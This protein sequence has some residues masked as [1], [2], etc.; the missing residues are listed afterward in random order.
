LT[1]VRTGANI[2]CMNIQSLNNSPE[3]TTRNPAEYVVLG[4]LSRGPIHGYDLYRSLT[5]D[6]GAVWS[7]GLSQVYA[8]L[9]RLEAAGLVRHQRSTRGRGPGRK[10]FQLTEAGR[11]AFQHWVETPVVHVRDIRLEFLAKLHFARLAGRGA[12]TRL[13]RAQRRVCRDKAEELRHGLEEARTEAER[14]ASELRLVMVEAILA[15]FDRGA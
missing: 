3:G 6:L 5:E 4:A 1:F 12:E 13:R 11:E 14:Q 9:S 7:L 10:T 8:L 2:Q 15:W